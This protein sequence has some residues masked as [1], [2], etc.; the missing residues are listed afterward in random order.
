VVVDDLLAH[1]KLLESRGLNRERIILDPGIGFGKT[2]E[3]NTELLEIAKY[4]PDYKVMVGYSRKRF[5]GEHRMELA[6]NLEAGRKAIASGAAY[7]RVHD[8]AGHRQLLY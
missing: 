1:A 2:M 7:L 4:L 6:A 5:L 8:V 3:L